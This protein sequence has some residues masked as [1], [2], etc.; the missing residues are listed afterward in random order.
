MAKHFLSLNDFSLEELN[1]ILAL[2][3]YLKAEMKKDRLNVDADYSLKGQILAMI[4]ESP[5]T[6]TR[7]SFDVAMR[8]LE[9]E[10]ITLAPGDMQ[11]GRGETIADTARVLSR[12]IDAIMIR[13]LD[14]DDLL[15]L[16]SHSD[17]PVINGLTKMEHP[18]QI[19]ADILTYQEHRGDVKGKIVSWFGPYN[20]VTRSLMQAAHIF[21]FELRIACPKEMAPSADET[22]PLIN[23]GS[24]IIV[25][26]DPVEAAKNADCFVTDV[27]ESMGDD[28]ATDIT[29]ILAPFQITNDLFS[30]AKDDA[31][32]M[33][34]LPAHRGEEVSADVIDGHRSVVFDE[35]ENRMHIQKAILAWLLK[36]S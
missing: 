7:V 19:L 18:C 2:A 13:I 11:L 24:K 23:A 12:Y 34:C 21:G 33:H 30:Y 15:E 29:A 6:R 22:T 4:F 26:H 27:W 31:L 35:A 10:T 5:S 8:Q 17:V 9:G 14:H 3:S 20:N 32:F 25:T 28:F 1:E 36:K 16:A